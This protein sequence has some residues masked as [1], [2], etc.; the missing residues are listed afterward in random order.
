MFY[1]ARLPALAILTTLWALSVAMSRAAMGRHYVGDVLAG[2][3]LGLVT[4]ATLGKVCICPCAV[5]LCTSF[6]HMSVVGT[7]T[8]QANHQAALVKGVVGG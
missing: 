3:L 1:A 8:P 5:Q 7:S 6:V 4:N 2:L